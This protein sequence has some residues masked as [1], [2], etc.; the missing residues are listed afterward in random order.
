MSDATPGVL[1]DAVTALA[2][3]S[4]QGPGALLRILL[5]ASMVGAALLA[6]FLLRGYRSNG[7]DD[8]HND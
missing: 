3:A 5:L 7:G 1:P 4:G 6:W 8:N 2:D